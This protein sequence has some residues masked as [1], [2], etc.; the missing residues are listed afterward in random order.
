M[1]LLGLHDVD[2]HAVSSASTPELSRQFPL[3]KDENTHAHT[4]RTGRYLREIPAMYRDD[5]PGG[6]RLNISVISDRLL[7]AGRGLHE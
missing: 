4:K 7:F 2:E 3:D 5:L 1:V 6:L